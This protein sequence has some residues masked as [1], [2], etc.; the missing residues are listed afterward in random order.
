MTCLEDLYSLVKLGNKAATLSTN[1]F[2]Q[3]F[4]NMPDITR[5]TRFYFSG[6][7]NDFRPQK[8]VESQLIPKCNNDKQ[9]K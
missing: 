9:A 4:L 7:H 2:R 5:V 8:G 3:V 1:C 6:I